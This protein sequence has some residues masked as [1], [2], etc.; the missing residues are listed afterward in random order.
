MTSAGAPL[1]WAWLGTVPYTEALAIQ[2]HLAV[3]RE[4]GSIPDSLL[5][6]EHPPVYTAGRGTKAE[7]LCGTPDRLR[8]FGAEFHEVDRGGSV[9]F[10]GPGQL[11][12]YPIVR[13]S[14]MFPVASAEAQGDVLR[15]LRALESALAATAA[16]VGV[17]AERRPPYTGVWIANRKVGAVGVKLAAGGITRH[18]V[19]LNVDTD[20]RWFAHVIP[21]GIRDGAVGS[22]VSEGAKGRPSPHSLAPLLAKALA[23][24]FGRTAVSVS[25][26][27]WPPARVALQTVP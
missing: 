4:A 12:A 8:A 23:V 18:G 16:R 19:A 5:L 14:E 27:L 2:Q 6:L 7:D 25:G 22:L 26:A 24:E 21:C 15:Y 3:Q 20:L 11:V 9:T 13:L 10:H 17:T 1:E